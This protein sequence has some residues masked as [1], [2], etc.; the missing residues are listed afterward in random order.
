MQTSQIREEFAGIK[1]RIDNATTACQ[2]SNAVP[3]ELREC[4]GELGRESDQARQV[5]E[6]ENNEN[7]IRQY[8]DRLEKLGDRAMHACRQDTNVDP[9]VADVVREAH[10]AISSLKHRLH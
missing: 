7:R 10:D 8:V 5:I 6:V 9:Q 2:I 4:L 3:D 1:Q